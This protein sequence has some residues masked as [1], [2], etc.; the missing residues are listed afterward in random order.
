[1]KQGFNG[2][3][4]L[5]WE[6][7]LDSISLTQPLVSAPSGVRCRQAPPPCPPRV[8]A[9]VEVIAMIKDDDIIILIYNNVNA[10]M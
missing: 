6:V 3:S 1:M 10:V 7:D 2:D 8:L 4:H 9:L 5:E